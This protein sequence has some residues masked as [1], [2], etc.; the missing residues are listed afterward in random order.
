MAEI[1][2]NPGR[3]IAIL[4]SLAAA[5]ALSAGLLVNDEKKVVDQRSNDTRSSIYTALKESHSADGGGAMQALKLKKYA[6]DE[7]DEKV[8]GKAA[9]DGDYNSAAEVVDLVWTANN[10]FAEKND[11]EGAKNAVDNAIQKLGITRSEFDRMNYAVKI[12]KTYDELHDENLPAVADEWQLAHTVNADLGEN[13]L[14]KYTNN[15]IGKLTQNIYG[16]INDDND[17][18][19]PMFLKIMGMSESEIRDM[20]LEISDV[21]KAENPDSIL[22]EKIKKKY[23]LKN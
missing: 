21:H 11:F 9:L 13:A 2:K 8:L 23:G 18:D 10:E 22:F 15:M 16:Y 20:I 5:G 12:R 4:A 7:Y 6:K 14:K 19:D 1:P 17:P 3:K